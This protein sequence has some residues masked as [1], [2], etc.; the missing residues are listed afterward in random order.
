LPVHQTFID[1][2]QYNVWHGLFPLFLLW[3]GYILTPRTTL[4]T[5]PPGHGLSGLIAKLTARLKA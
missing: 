5:S 1:S 3:N 2:A 4:L